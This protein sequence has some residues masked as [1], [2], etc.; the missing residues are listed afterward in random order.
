MRF[1]STPTFRH[2]A[3]AHS[4]MHLVIAM[5]SDA[6]TRRW[7]NDILRL[8][9]RRRSRGE[10]A[11]VLAPG[12]AAPVTRKRRRPADRR[13]VLT[14]A[15]LRSEVFSSQVFALCSIVFVLF[16]AGAVTAQLVDGGAV[17]MDC[18]ECDC[19]GSSDDGTIVVFDNPSSGDRVSLSRRYLVYGTNLQAP[20]VFCPVRALE[21]PLYFVNKFVI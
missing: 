19:T 10:A 17:T 16:W 11:A 13:S 7:R 20:P 6:R 21:Q 5:R 8:L 15:R 9:T 12:T 1:L 14:S 18:G 3:C 4:C 2:R